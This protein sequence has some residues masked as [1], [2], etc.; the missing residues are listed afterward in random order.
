[1]SCQ[2][3]IKNRIKNRINNKRRR[4]NEFKSIAGR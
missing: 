4:S 1:L 3:R 2:N